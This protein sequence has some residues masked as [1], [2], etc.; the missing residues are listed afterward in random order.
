MS[1]ALGIISMILGVSVIPWIVYLLTR[2]PK[3]A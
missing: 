3:G 2:K 1:T